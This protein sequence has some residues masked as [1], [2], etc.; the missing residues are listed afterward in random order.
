MSN[1]IFHLQPHVTCDF[2]YTDANVSFDILVSTYPEI[3]HPVVQF[4]VLVDRGSAFLGTN[5]AHHITQKAPQPLWNVKQMNC[6]APV[7]Y[8]FS[9]L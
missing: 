6:C 8:S 2:T 1:N 3:N 7:F 9:D 4:G 5:K